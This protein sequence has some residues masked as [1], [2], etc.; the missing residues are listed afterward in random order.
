[1]S[2]VSFAGIQKNKMNVIPTIKNDDP[3]N[4]FICFIFNLGKEE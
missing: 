1:M 4:E 2:N 3:F